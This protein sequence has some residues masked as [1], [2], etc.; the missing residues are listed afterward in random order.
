MTRERDD[1]GWRGAR[2]GGLCEHVEP[3]AIRQ[4][5]VEEHESRWPAGALLHGGGD[6]SRDPG[7]VARGLEQE[8]ERV[9]GQ[10]VVL[11]DQDV[12]GRLGSGERTAQRRRHAASRSMASMS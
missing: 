3:V 7:L 1:D 11:D 6:G 12:S 4:C 8:P 5:Q 10:R 2:R 9:R